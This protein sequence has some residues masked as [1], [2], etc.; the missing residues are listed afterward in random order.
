VTGFGSCGYI[1]TSR[2][3]L[4]VAMLTTVM[5]VSGFAQQPHR[6]DAAPVAG[7]RVEN[8]IA[9]G[10]K[11]EQRMDVYLPR[12]ARRSPIIVMVHG[13]AW[14]FGSKEAR[15]VVDNKVS[16]W[17]PKGF[18]FVSVET[19][20]VPVAD[21]LQQAADVAAAMAAVQRQAVSWGGDPS[22]IVL[23]GHSAGAHLVA[24]VSAD[25]S[26]ARK[27]GLKPWAGTIALDSA[28]YDVSSIMERPDHPRLYDRAFGGDPD[29]WRK[30]SPAL[31]A[32]AKLPPI[33]LVCSSL[34][35]DS[36][37]QADAFAAKSR[38]Q[39]RVLPV[40]LRH[41]VINRTL[42]LEGRYTSQVDAFIN[43]IVAR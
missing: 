19:R 33:L 6:A 2:A 39:A 30:A 27:A 13:G 41:A 7:V 35:Q 20:L 3:L 34:R 37:P 17:L 5:A 40:A 23:M 25:G 21:P 9:Y 1:L 8:D 28:A 24:L 12:N 42:G 29:F 36:C 18:I 38:G 14:A 15:G 32:D 10:W 11:P 26:I 31:Y 43:S 22:R 16:Y 4:A